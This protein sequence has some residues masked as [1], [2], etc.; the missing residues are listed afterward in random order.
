MLMRLALSTWVVH[1]MGQIG[2]VLLPKGGG[3][4]QS[5]TQAAVTQ[6]KLLK[7]HTL[8]W[9][10][11]CLAKASTRDMIYF[12]KLFLSQAHEAHLMAPF[13]L[14]CHI[15][16]LLRHTVCTVLQAAAARWA[17]LK[18]GP[19]IPAVLPIIGH[20]SAWNASLLGIHA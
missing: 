20:V 19:S 6:A 1:C 11:K 7:T 5:D 8:L 12:L 17:T 2:G 9:S 16:R 4:A 13:H 3:G 14:H 18:N 10:C 15:Y